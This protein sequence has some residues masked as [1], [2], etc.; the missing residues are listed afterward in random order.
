[1]KENNKAVKFKFALGIEVEDITCG[2]TGIITCRYQCLNGCLQYTVTPR[3]KSAT[4]DR[5][6]A[7][8]IDEECLV[9][10]SAGITGK[11]KTKAPP[12]ATGGPS[13]RASSNRA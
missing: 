1:M 8:N 12:K 9:K 10:V 3:M 4:S 7:W 6:D 5:K 2:F 13:S 11:V